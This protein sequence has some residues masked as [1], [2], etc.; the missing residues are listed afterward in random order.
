MTVP[1][2]LHCANIS[3]ISR[4][5]CDKD[6]PGRLM[7]TMVCAA[8]EGGGTDSCEVSARRGP[9]GMKAGRVRSGSGNGL[10]FPLLGAREGASVSCR[11]MNTL[12]ETVVGVRV[13]VKDGHRGEA[14]RGQDRPGLGMGVSLGP[15]G[16]RK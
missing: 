1:D 8:A 13:R 11:Q 3:V 10:P 7:D 4:A 16:N 12:L 5:A 2:T 15:M 14:G 9:R 6:Y